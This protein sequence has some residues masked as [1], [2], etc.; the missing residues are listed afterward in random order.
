MNF[1]IKKI[2]IAELYVALVVLLPFSVGEAQPAVDYDE[3]SIDE[4]FSEWDQPDSPG[5]AI[6]I[7]HNGNLIFSNGY[8]NAVLDQKKPITPQTVFYS[9]SVSKQFTAAAI[10][11]LSLRG[12]L[13]LDRPVRDYIPEMPAY[14]EH[15]DPTVRQLI[16]H[17]SGLPDLYSLLS[18]YDMD[19]E[20]VLPFEEMVEV[21]TG[22]SHL[23]FEPGSEYLY[24][25]SGYTLLAELVERVSGQTLREYTTEH[26]FEPLGMNNT[27]FHDDR[28]HQ[29][30]NQAL[31][32]QPND[33]GGFE[34]SY[35]ANFEGV[36]PGGLYTTVEDMLKWNQQLTENQLPN[37]EGFNELMHR[38]GVLSTGDT[39]DYAFALNIDEYKGEKKVDHSGTFMGFKA[40]YL[41][42]P[43]QEYGSTILCNVGSADPSALNKELAD[44]FWSDQ[45]EKWLSQYQGAYYS[46]ALDLEYNLQIKGA[47]LHLD[48]K[49]SPSGKLLHAGDNT[50]R[51]GS[52]EI[53]FQE[54]EQG[55]VKGFSIFSGRANNIFF[56]K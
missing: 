20:E 25:N 37:A 8:G 30:N 50:F 6:G 51:T 17:T 7:Y 1:F 40:H 28:H 23:N 32:Y 46:E 36:G 38:R 5:C 11:L 42:L 19:L 26:L 16:H 21:I 22:Q 56:K 53:K 2:G 12:E 41:R 31:S 4:I 29:I 43:D 48:R 24:S 34:K 3:D 44:L 35:L 47:N 39:L 45:F 52:W 54:T 33:N 9:G 14:A 15:Q 55:E 49:T 13:E 10:A 18:L 27:H